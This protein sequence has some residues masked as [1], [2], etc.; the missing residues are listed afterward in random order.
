MLGAAEAASPSPG[1]IWRALAR[2]APH[3]LSARLTCLTLLLAPVG[4]W[5]VRPF[6]LALSAAGLLLPGLWRSPWLWAALTA[7]TT[8]RFW[9]DWPLADNHAYLLAY[10]CL[11]LTVAAWLRD[12]RALA[13]NARLL[14]GLT[15]ALAA[16][17]KWFSPD[18]PNGLFFLTTFMLD[19]RFEDFAVL[20]TSVSYEH[21]DAARAYLEADYRTG[22]AGPFPFAVPPSL[23]VL[24]WLATGWNLLE[25]TL[26]AA[27]FLAPPHTR[28]GR[29]RDPALLVFCFTTYAVAPVTGFGWLL[30]AM[31]SAQIG[32]ALATRLWYLGAFAALAFY[33]QVPWARLLVEIGW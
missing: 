12:G 26:V 18:Y 14:L 32:C 23:W 24:A 19:E 6:V 11:A 2:L 10:W 13:L 28:L 17:Q 27:A 7:L 8:L 4:D 20:C 16:L 15:F 29:L 31:G 3:E 21:I 25:Q 30:L 9:L 22:E 33:D 5:S 1:G